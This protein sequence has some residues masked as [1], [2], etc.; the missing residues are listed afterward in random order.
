MGFRT[1]RQW[2]AAVLVVVLALA[3]VVAY[4]VRPRGLR[5]A[6]KAAAAQAAKTR[7]EVVRVMGVPPGRYTDPHPD[8]GLPPGIGQ[9]HSPDRECL[10]WIGL[11]CYIT[12]IVQNGTG[13]VFGVVV[14]YPVR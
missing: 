13:Y 14:N 1:R 11:D 6:D 8:F 5:F 10:T 7:A 9:C 4:Y 2:A 12:A 3:L